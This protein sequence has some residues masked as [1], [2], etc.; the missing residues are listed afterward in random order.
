[1]N[2]ARHLA[3]TTTHRE[4]LLHDV[5]D[6]APNARSVLR[7]TGQTLCNCCGRMS[8]SPAELTHESWCIYV[9]EPDT[10]PL[11]N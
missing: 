4:L 9:D 5:Y 6:L 1:M 10:L 2:T 7:T 11:T 8:A 3:D